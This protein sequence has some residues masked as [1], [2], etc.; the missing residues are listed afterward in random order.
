MTRFIFLVKYRQELI[1]NNWKIRKSVFASLR[2]TGIS[3]FYTSIVLFFGFSVFMTSSYGGTIALGG[4]VSTTLLFAMLANLVLL[5]SLLIS[6]E[7][8]ISNKKD[9]KNSVINLDSN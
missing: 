9:L 5:P 6:L 7:K 3:M 8:S 2:E 4:L 1:A